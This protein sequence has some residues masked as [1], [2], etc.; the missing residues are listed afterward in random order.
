MRNSVG[1]VLS[2]V[3]V[4]TM[5][6]GCGSKNGGSKN[7]GPGPVDVDQEFP[8]SVF[9]LSEMSKLQSSYGESVAQ[10]IVWNVRV[11]VNGKEV[12]KLEKAKIADVKNNL[13]NM[14]F[15]HYDLVR[16]EI[17]VVAADGKV[18][19]T[20]VKSVA[21]KEP[22]LKQI[23]DEEC[24]HLREPETMIV[25]NSTSLLEGETKN[26]VQIKLEICDFAGYALKPLIT[27]KPQNKNLEKKLVSYKCTFTPTSVYANTARPY[28]KRYEDTACTYGYEKLPG[29]EDL[30]IS[31]IKDFAPGTALY[32]E[33][34]LRMDDFNLTLGNADQYFLDIPFFKPPFGSLQ[35][36]HTAK[37]DVKMLGDSG[38]ETRRLEF[39]KNSSGSGVLWMPSPNTNFPNLSKIASYYEQSN[40]E[41]ITLFMLCD[42]IPETND[43][44]AG[45]VITIDAN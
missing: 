37:V 23:W 35:T 32:N 11:S 20:N 22:E 15:K 6:L 17:T 45:K 25:D 27:I 9:D 33:K 7:G 13:G 3:V 10:E 38:I 28:L 16:T 2:G 30:K 43:L 42:F 39:K 21:E 40:T 34:M 29:E 24:S 26:R 8:N 14:Q 12:S 19:S 5:M 36:C 31:I 41:K 44:D 4:G 18:L 1:K